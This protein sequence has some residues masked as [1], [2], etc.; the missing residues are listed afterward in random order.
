MAI[1][2]D[3]AFGIFEDLLEEGLRPALSGFK[4]QDD[5]N[6]HWP[7]GSE[8]FFVSARL[9]MTTR[10]GTT[11]EELTR[12]KDIAEKHGLVAWFSGYQGYTGED[13]LP[14]YGFVVKFEKG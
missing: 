4:S 8:G 1:T 3:Q 9:E 5:R 14:V 7:K 12:M 11:I 13:E 10:A 6:Q 2:R